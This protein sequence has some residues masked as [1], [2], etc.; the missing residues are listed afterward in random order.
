MVTA[1]GSSM[2][3]QGYAAP[4]FMPPP[5]MPNFGPAPNI[6]YGAPAPQGGPALP[7]PGIY[8]PPPNISYGAPLP[9][10]GP[11]NF[12]PPAGLPQITMPP[13]MMSQAGPYGPMPGGPGMSYLA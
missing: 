5:P 13:N 10:P 1:P 2:I 11:Y 3:S 8:G 12:L 9:Q 4:G 6:S 7:P